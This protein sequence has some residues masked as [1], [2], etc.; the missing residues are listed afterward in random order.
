MTKS[1][2]ELDKGLCVVPVCRAILALGPSVGDRCKPCYEYR[3]KH[4]H[5]R[6]KP[7]VKGLF[8]V[9]SPCR[10]CGEPSTRAGLCDRCYVY[11]GR[12]GKPRPKKLDQT[13]PCIRCGSTGS[14]ARTR[15]M[16]QPC[17]LKIMRPYAKYRALCVMLLHMLTVGSCDEGTLGR[18]N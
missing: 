15:H 11:R 2:A 6:T 14:K 12:T 4:G 18:E 16:C 7:R 10:D 13:Q 1:R 9:G 17:Y 3:R 5:D 8:P